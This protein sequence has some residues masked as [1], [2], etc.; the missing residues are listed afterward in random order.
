MCIRYHFSSLLG[1]VSSLF[2]VSVS[3]SKG[4]CLLLCVQAISP[5]NC[6]SHVFHNQCCCSECKSVNELWH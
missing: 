4:M 2:V 5:L 3:K 1:I 6:A